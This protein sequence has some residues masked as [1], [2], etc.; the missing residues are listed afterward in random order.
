M[1][2]GALAGC[3]VLITRPEHQSHE[4]TAAIDAATGN[5][6]HFPAIDIIGRDINEIQKDFAT[7]PAPDI[8]VFV[9]SNAVAHGFTV[10]KG[11]NAIIA[12]VGPATRAAIEAAGAAADIFP[13]DGFDSEHLLEHAGLQEV[14]GKN[15][16]ILRGQSGREL[17]ADTLIERGANVDYLCVY[18]RAPHAPAPPELEKLE[19]ILHQGR[20]HFM[21][22]M[23]VETLELLVQIL[24]SQCL[25]LLRQST[26]VAPSTRVLQTA[27]KLIPG[28]AT[29]LAPGPQ[30]PTMV[31]TLIKLW[32]TG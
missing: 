27:S 8:V 23:S 9:S 25:S 15:I 1:S 18:S 13:E 14:S 2:D 21:T 11:N 30:A 28:I 29:V 31:K 24:P 7:L 22:V 20:V 3:G 17:L 6:F 10:V 19:S 4:L 12:A 26:L 5:V 32:Q 16:V